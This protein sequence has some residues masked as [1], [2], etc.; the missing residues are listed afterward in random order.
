MV[1]RIGL[2]CGMQVSYLRP[3][4]LTT[5]E[6]GS[7]FSKPLKRCFTL[8]AMRQQLRIEA[9]AALLHSSSILIFLKIM[10]LTVYFSRILQLHE[11]LNFAPRLNNSLLTR[12]FGLDRRG[13]VSLF[14]LKN[15]TE[16]CEIGK[17]I[18]DKQT[19]FF[20]ETKIRIQ[21]RFKAQSGVNKKVLH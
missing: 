18:C 12:R 17:S 3:L 2:F 13:N 21:T 10:S 7:N 9:H 19:Y 4:L 1:T 14:C 8:D 16:I 5:E 11:L 20:F 15:G 6:L